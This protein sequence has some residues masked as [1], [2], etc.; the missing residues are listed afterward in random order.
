MTNSPSTFKEFLPAPNPDLPAVVFVNDLPPG[1][2][3]DVFANT[4]RRQGYEVTGP[5]YGT[6]QLYDGLGR[7]ETDEEAERRFRVAVVRG[8]VGRRWDDGKDMT[9]LFP[10]ILDN[11]FYDTDVEPCVVYVPTEPG[12]DPERLV[13][14]FGYEGVVPYHGS[15]YVMALRT[16]RMVTELTTEQLPSVI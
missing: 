8:T 16:A 10:R 1:L 11:E 7:V 4:L 5:C 12:V 2:E 9:H 15:P 6:Q 13:D 3:E 14:L